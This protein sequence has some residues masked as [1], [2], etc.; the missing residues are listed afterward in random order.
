MLIDTHLVYTSRTAPKISQLIIATKANDAQN[1]FTSVANSLNENSTVMFLQNGFG[2][3]DFEKLTKSHPHLQFLVS[4]TNVGA[5]FNHD[6]LY[7][8]SNGGTF[9]IS[10]INGDKMNENSLQVLNKLS[11]LD[12]ISVT[13]MDYQE[14]YQ[15]C[16]L[17]LVANSCINAF[18]TI[19]KCTNGQI[20]Q[21]NRELVD[22]ILNEC[23]DVLN[24]E[25]TCTKRYVYDIIEKTQGNYNS[26]YTD[27]YK[28]GKSAS[29]TEIK[30]ING[31]IIQKGVENNVPTPI[32]RRVFDDFYNVFQ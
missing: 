31:Y 24:L 17:K 13:Q 9:N 29:K 18:A 2:F 8:C 10:L 21:I 5:N 12:G 30:Y 20:L 22:C 15:V 3:V 11:S 4:N 26:T 14:F 32:N 6:T 16:L 28:L 19:H 23:C 27:I 7:E 25:K 1:A